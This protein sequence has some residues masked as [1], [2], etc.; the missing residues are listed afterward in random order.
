MLGTD[1]YG[2]TFAEWQ[3]LAGRIMRDVEVRLFVEQLSLVGC[4]ILMAAVSLL[5]EW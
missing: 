5:I 2:W 1:P 4:R 3:M